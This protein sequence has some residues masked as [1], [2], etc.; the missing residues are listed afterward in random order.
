MIILN[1]IFH[2]HNIDTANAKAAG[3][4]KDEQELHNDRAVLW[5]EFNTCWLSALN[6]QKQMMAE[7]LSSSP[8]LQPPSNLIKE[9]QLEKMGRELVRLC[10]NME[11]HGLVD[12][13]MGVWEEEILEGK[14]VSKL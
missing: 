3:L 2:H 8:S 6:R 10:D 9:D 1:A 13:Q 14:C 5:T 11:R 12:Y 4:V 7:H